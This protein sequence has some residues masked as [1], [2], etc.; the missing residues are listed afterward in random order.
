MTLDM[1]NATVKP[2][3]TGTLNLHFA[4]NDSPWT[5]WICIFGTVTQNNYLESSSFMN[6]FA[7][8]RR[9]LGLC[10]SSLSLNQILDVGAV[11]RVA[12]YE[13][14]MARNGLYDNDEDEFFQYCDAAI[15]CSSTS[16]Q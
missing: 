10:A 7:R 14:A 1:F 4:L 3:V 11:S 5:S 16:S 12:N 2:R 8:Y 6:A 15:D 9:S 13:T